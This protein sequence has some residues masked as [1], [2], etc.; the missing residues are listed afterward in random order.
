MPR[1]PSDAT[2]RRLHLNE[3]V[4]NL[5]MHLGSNSDSVIA[6]KQDEFLIFQ[7]APAA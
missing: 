1:P 5:G 4:E 3:H 6:Y 7:S 2:I